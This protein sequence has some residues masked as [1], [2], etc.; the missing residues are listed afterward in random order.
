[1]ESK[2][3][4]AEK[5]MEKILIE[6][7]T[8]VNES[9]LTTND[10]NRIISAGAKL[11]EK[12]KELRES[13]DKSITR[14]DAAEGKL[15]MFIIKEGERKTNKRERPK[16][17]KC[18][19]MISDPKSNKTGMCSACSMRERIRENYVSQSKQEADK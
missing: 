6:C 7:E 3:S 1:M 14:R 18:G 11:L 19:K 16:K 17:C 2:K 9:Y 8:I 15:K 13:R 4:A 10:A 12:C 5:G